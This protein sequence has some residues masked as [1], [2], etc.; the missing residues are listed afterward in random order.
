MRA[1]TGV[2]FPARTES[3]PYLKIRREKKLARVPRAR[4]AGNGDAP[5]ATAVQLPAAGAGPCRR[6]GLFKAARAGS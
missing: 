4:D 6:K 2:T 5:K 3:A 1:V